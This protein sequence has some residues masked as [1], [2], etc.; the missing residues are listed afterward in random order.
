MMAP[1]GPP[2]TSPGALARSLLRRQ[3][4]PVRSSVPQRL[5]G[6][7]HP[8]AADASHC[9]HRGGDSPAPGPSP[10]G[11][12]GPSGRRPRLSGSQPS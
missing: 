4:A 7:H 9:S 3:R 5:R 12:P 6:A 10:R 1:R 2:P 11:V 8:G